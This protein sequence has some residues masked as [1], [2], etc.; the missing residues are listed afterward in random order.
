[1]RAKLVALILT[2]LLA[3]VSGNAAFANHQPGHRA[4]NGGSC[5]GASPGCCGPP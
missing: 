4:G 5:N 1:M 3:L 2:L